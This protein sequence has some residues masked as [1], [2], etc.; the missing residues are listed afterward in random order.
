MIKTGIG[1]LAPPAML[2][3][4]SRSRLLDCY[5]ALD[6]HAARRQLLYKRTALNSNALNGLRVGVNLLTH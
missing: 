2:A 5:D 3:G 4:Q 6:P 1:Y